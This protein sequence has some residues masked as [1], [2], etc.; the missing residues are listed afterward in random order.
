MSEPLAN[1]TLVLGLGR[2]G[3]EVCALL[4]RETGAQAPPNL[5]VLEAGVGPTTSDASAEASD[6]SA[7]GPWLSSIAD[8]AATAALLERLRELARGLL[9]LKLRVATTGATDPPQPGMTRR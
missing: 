2:F 1:P 4:V 5:V 3:H 7:D 6:A 8:E 9:D